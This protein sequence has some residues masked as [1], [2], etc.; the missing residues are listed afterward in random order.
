MQRALRM[1]PYEPIEVFSNDRR[2]LNLDEFG[3]LGQAVAA[4]EPPSSATS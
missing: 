2:L 1:N 3:D 4:V